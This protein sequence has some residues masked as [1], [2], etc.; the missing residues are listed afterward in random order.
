MRKNI[1]VKKPR[2]IDPVVLAKYSTV[3]IMHPYIERYCDVY[4][5]DLADH[6]SLNDRHLPDALAT[7]TLLTPMCGNKKRIIGSGLMSERQYLKARQHLFCKMKDILDKN[8]PVLCYTLSDHSSST[9]DKDDDIPQCDNMNHGKAM[10]ELDEFEHF[11]RKKY[12]LKVRGTTARCLTGESCVIMVG[13]V[14]E[15]GKHL[16]SGHNLFEYID[17][18]G[19]INVV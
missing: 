4:S 6:L 13:P 2:A 5:K 1:L 8:D 19:R 15:K 10:E 3:K 9:D 17:I 11:K 14:E 12:Q 7:P 18:Q 16:P